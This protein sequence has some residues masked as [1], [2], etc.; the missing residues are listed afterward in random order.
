[1]NSD[2]NGSRAGT[3]EE[4]AGIVLMLA[5]PAGNFLNASNCV[6]DGGWHLNASAR[7]I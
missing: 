7:D 3:W 1:M 4:I 2:A 5:S 6:V